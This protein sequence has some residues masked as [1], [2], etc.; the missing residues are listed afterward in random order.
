M[1]ESSA[2]AVQQSTANG[3]LPKRPAAR[4]LDRKSVV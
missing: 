4:V 3:G 1:T 2:P